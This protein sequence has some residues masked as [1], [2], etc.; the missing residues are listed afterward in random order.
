[1]RLFLEF[2]KRVRHRAQTRI[3]RREHGSRLEFSSLAAFAGANAGEN[4]DSL[5]DGRDR[6]D[7]EPSLF[8]R[9]NHFITKHQIFD[10]LCWNQYSLR[11]RETFQLAHVIETLDLLIHA[12][13]R[14]HVTLLVYR[15]GHR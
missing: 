7:M 10:V 8:H 1:M 2:S 6:I 3:N 5:L 11:S 9:V 13:D 12:A 4:L 14:L 15:P